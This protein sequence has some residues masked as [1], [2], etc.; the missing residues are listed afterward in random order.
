[1][2]MP[3]VNLTDLISAVVWWNI[4]ANARNA[5]PDLKYVFYFDM[6]G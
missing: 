6:G 4:T 3:I 5:P 2:I 1:M